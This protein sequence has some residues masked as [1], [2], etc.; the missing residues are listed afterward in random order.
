VDGQKTKDS[1][2]A[3]RFERTSTATFP[4]PDVSK[5]TVPQVAATVVQGLTRGA[6]VAIV[7]WFVSETL[8][9]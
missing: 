4:G 3:L 9:T 2:G 8:G 6:D 1:T 5:G 7:L